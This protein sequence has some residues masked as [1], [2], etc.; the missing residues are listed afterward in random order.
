MAATHCGGARHTPL[1]TL[2][3][4]WN[5][6]RCW[7][8]QTEPAFKATFKVLFK[9]VLTCHLN[10][11]LSSKTHKKSKTFVSWSPVSQRAHNANKVS[12]KGYMKAH[13]CGVSCRTWW[14]PSSAHHSCK[15]GGN[16]KLTFLVQTKWPMHNFSAGPTER[17]S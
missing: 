12:E 8:S 5:H 2:A 7:P 3:Q 14:G 4:V 17:H 1:A 15:I 11:C 10:S 6:A 9:Q 13:K 16:T